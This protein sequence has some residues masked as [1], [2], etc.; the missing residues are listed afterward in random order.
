LFL[1]ARK[2]EAQLVNY[3]LRGRYYVVDRLFDAAELRLGTKHQDIVRIDRLV[4]KH[5]RRAL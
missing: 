1:V 2:G 4:G 3:R 5:G